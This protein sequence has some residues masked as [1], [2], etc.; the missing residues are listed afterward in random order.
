MEAENW[1]GSGAGRSGRPPRPC[2]SPPL[3]MGQGRERRSSCEAGSCSH[4]PAPGL[5]RP[6]FSL[7]CVT[8]GVVL[9][10]GVGLWFD[11]V[12]FLAFNFL[13]QQVPV[14]GQRRPDPPCPGAGGGLRFCDTSG[15]VGSCEQVSI[16]LPLEGEAGFLWEPSESAWGL[17]LAG[18]LGFL[19]STPLPSSLRGV[20]LP[21]NTACTFASEPSRAEAS[22]GAG[23]APAGQGSLLREGRGATCQSNNSNK[24]GRGVLCPRPLSPLTRRDHKPTG[25]LRS[26]A[27]AGVCRLLANG[28]LG[29]GSLSPPQTSHPLP[30]SGSGGKPA[31]PRSSSSQCSAGR[32]ALPPAGAQE[33]RGRGGPR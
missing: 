24:G 8:L 20:F 5:S 22:R 17:F 12:L 21:P 26:R 19:L 16:A 2:P 7:C 10:F 32:G 1:S 18:G 11:Y 28:D 31:I 15:P 29:P 4:T 9:S 14:A 13:W 30:G 25:L 23:A 27:A 33:L 6:F 3:P